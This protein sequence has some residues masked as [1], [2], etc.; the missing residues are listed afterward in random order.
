MAMSTT[1]IKCAGSVA[2][3]EGYNSIP[4]PKNILESNG[5]VCLDTRVRLLERKN[6]ITNPPPNF[7]P[8]W[9]SLS[10]RICRLQ[11]KANVFCRKEHPSNAVLSILSDASDVSIETF[12][13]MCVDLL[14][15][16]VRPMIQGQPTF[17]LWPKSGMDEDI[18]TVVRETM[19]HI[20][21]KNNLLLLDNIPVSRQ[22]I[23]KQLVSLA[24]FLD[25][26]DGP[27]IGQ[28]APPVWGHPNPYGRPGIGLPPPP[29]IIGCGPYSN[30]CSD[31]TSVVSVEKRSSAK[32]F[33]GVRWL[34]SLF[35]V[36]QSTR[37]D[38]RSSTSSRTMY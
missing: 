14:Q 19:C 28:L 8:T 27:M 37:D 17:I 7:Q 35:C 31:V 34:K 26:S 16:N 29:Q 36:R 22:E 32:R 6:K 11:Y 25:P 3:L 15:P 18:L 21:G 12:Q 4:L 23:Y 38:D 24:F 5:L 30:S 1:N 20:A 10:L 13:T 33:F 9:D 2:A